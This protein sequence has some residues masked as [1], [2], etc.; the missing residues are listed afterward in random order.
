MPRPRIKAR[1]SVVGGKHSSKELFEQPINSYSEHLHMSRDTVL[2]ELL[3]YTTG[4]FEI[5]SLDVILN[6]LVIHCLG[7]KET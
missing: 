7:L 6:W 2:Y 4:W 1:A 5:F 3:S